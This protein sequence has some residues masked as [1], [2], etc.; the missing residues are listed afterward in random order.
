MSET[1]VELRNHQDD[2][3]KSKTSVVRQDRIEAKDESP[4]HEKLD[5]GELWAELL[6]A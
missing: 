6:N 5:S 4:K 1:P 2:D 3:S